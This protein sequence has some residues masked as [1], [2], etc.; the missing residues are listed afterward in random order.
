MKWKNS[1]SPELA[2]TDAAIQSRKQRWL[3]F[4]DLTSPRRVAYLIRYAPELLPRPLPNPDCRQER[5]EWIWQNYEYHLRRMDWLKDDTV[6]CLDML[7]GTEIFAEAFGCKVY[8][9]EDNNPFAQPCAQNAL[10]ADR[11][12]VPS[13]DVPPL[14]FVFKMAD[15]LYRRAGPGVLF[16]LVDLQSPMDVAALIWEKTDFYTVL[17]E[18]PVAVIGLVEKIKTLQFAFLDE[19]FRRYGREFIA[20]YP[21]YYLPQGVTLS[22]DEIGAISGKM[23]L[24]YFLPDIN[25][26]SERYG[27]L[28]IH[29]CAHAR[30]QWEHFKKIS[31][32][33][34]LNINNQGYMVREAYSFFVDF[35]PQWNND[36]SPIP[37]TPLEWLKEIPANAH[38]VFDIV[39]ETKEDAL[40][41]SEQ[42]ESFNG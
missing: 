10:E 20:H 34:M 35:V 33:R 37:L 25:Q 14:A 2:M 31:G 8:R 17:L 3:D 4:Y 1:C 28:G 30:H 39:A 5:L 41:I 26:F 38:I 11:L 13:L 23:F 16:R 29:C 24:Q 22:V 7:T 40:Q 19:W 12:K 21:D 9:P 42:M 18:N 36:Q 32:L 27:G 15:E 6:P